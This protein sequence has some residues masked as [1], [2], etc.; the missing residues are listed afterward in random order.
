MDAGGPGAILE[1][2]QAPVADAA[3][4]ATIIDGRLVADAAR[5]TTIIIDGRLE[6]PAAADLKTG[7]P[8][9]PSVLQAIILH[10]PMKACERA[11][12]FW[13]DVRPAF[14]LP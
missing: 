4:I 6:P 5:I 2:P 1:A 11:P 14:L 8:R 13:A 9:C 7:T 3:R 10:K 12:R